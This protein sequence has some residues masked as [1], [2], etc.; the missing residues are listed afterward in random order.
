[1]RQRLGEMAQSKKRPVEN[2]GGDAVIDPGS[3]TEKIDLEAR[4]LAR[5][6]VAPRFSRMPRPDEEPLMESEGPLRCREAE[7]TNSGRRLHDLEAVGD[8][9]DAAADASSIL[10][11][12]ADWAARPNTISGS[13]RGSTKST[14][15]TFSASSLRLWTVPS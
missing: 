2:V 13:M 8:P 4:E 5:P 9:G 7:T 11:P 14:E 3:V 6:L 15:G 10:I 12:G 1:M